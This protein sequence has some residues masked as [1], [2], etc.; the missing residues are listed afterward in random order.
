MNSAY[1]LFDQLILDPELTKT[2][3]RDAFFFTAMDAYIHSTESLNGSYRNA[4]G[5]AFA[6]QAITLCREV[7]N[8][9]ELQSDENCEKIMVASYLSGCSLANSFVGIIH[10]LSAGLGI[11]LGVH[12]CLA[13][14]MVLN[15]LGEFYPE[16]AGELKTW[17][18]KHQVSLPEQATKDLQQ[19]GFTQLYNSS[20]IHEKPLINALGSGFKDI[21]TVDKVTEIYQAI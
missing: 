6:Q 7:F 11:V 18:A 19:E 20:I 3:P 2:V 12:H 15:Q 10:P 14:C 1:T 4:I 5:D 13:N 21:L 17:L 9:D 8:S 16:A